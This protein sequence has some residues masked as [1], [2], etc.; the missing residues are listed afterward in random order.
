MRFE[1]RTK[2]RLRLFEWGKV[3]ELHHKTGDLAESL[4]R[5]IHRS[6]RECR[7]VAIRKL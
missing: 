5:A 4:V 3:K 7:G 6:G 1:M 2:E